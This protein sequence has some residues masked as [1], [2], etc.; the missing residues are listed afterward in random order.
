VDERHTA[1][2]LDEEYEFPGYDAVQERFWDEI[3]QL[4]NEWETPQ[5]NS[6]L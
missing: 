1:T 5:D 6:K 2:G 4:R 3:E